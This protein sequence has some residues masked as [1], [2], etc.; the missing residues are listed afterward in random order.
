VFMDHQIS[1]SL[2]PA[3]QIGL[4]FKRAYS[5]LGKSSR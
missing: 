5:N 2:S 4:K 1:L 3:M